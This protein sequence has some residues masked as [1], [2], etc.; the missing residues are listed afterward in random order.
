MNAGGERI[1]R[2]FE[3][4]LSRNADHRQVDPVRNRRDLRVPLN[5]RNRLTSSIDRICS[6]AKLALED[7]PE[8]LAANRSTSWRCADHGDRPRLEERPQGFDDCRMVAKIYALDVRG[9]RRDRER[10]LDDPLGPRTID[11]E[12]GVR[13]DGQHR[14]VARQDLRDEALD[15]SR[16]GAGSELLEEARPETVALQLV[17]HRECN[18]RGSRV[19]ES[20]PA[21]ERDDALLLRLA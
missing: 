17:R 5:T 10:D 18:L 6:A 19:A 7:V 14:G 11:L 12:A 13:K 3:H 21:G 16:A 15:P 20:R 8:K 9:R 2:R 1:L 4:V